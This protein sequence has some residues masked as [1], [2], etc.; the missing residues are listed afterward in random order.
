M[1]TSDQLVIFSLNGISCALPL[2]AVERVYRAVEVTPL[3]KVPKIVLGLVNTRGKLL[4]VLDIRSLFSLP[5][6]EVEPSDHLLIARTARRTV[7]LL[8]D[9]VTDTLVLDESRQAVTIPGDIVPGIKHLQGVVK[10]TDGPLLIHDLDTF[11]SIEEELALD[12]A[13][14]SSEAQDR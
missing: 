12:L 2:P 5:P 3:P 11:L 8:V 10:L 13:L 14:T 1:K 6:K 4:P 7:A 9:Q